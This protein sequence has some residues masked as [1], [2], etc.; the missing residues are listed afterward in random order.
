MKGG[1]LQHNVTLLRS[2]TSAAFQFG[3]SHYKIT[4]DGVNERTYQELCHEFGELMERV[5]DELLRDAHPEDYVRFHVHSSE[6]D[7]DINTPFQRRA[8]CAS[9]WIVAVIDKTMQSHMLIDMND[10][11]FI[12]VQHARTPTGG[13][14]Q[15]KIRVDSMENMLA[16]HSVITNLPDHKH[17]PCFGYALLASQRLKETNRLSLLRWSR[18]MKKVEREV[19]DLFRR[20]NVQEG[21]VEFKDYDSFQKILPEKYRLVVVSTGGK[22]IIYKGQKGDILLCV[23]L[24]NN[25][26][27][28]ALS[29]LTSWSGCEVYCIEC[30][31]GYNTKKRHVCKKNRVCGRCHGQRCSAAPKAAEG[32]FCRDCKGIFGNSKCYRDHLTNKICEAATTC[33]KCGRWFPGVVSKH[34][35]NVEKCMTCQ[36]FHSSSHPC[37]IETLD[38]EVTGEFHYIFYDFEAFQTDTDPETGKHV[39]KV[40]FCVAMEVCLRCTD[41]Q[42]CDCERLRVFRGLD[43][44]DVVADFLKWA[45]SVNRRNATLIAHNS[46]GYDGHF[47]LDYLVKNEEYPEM[48]MQGGKILSMKVKTTNSRF[49]DSHSFLAMGLSKFTATFGLGGIEKGQFPHMF[50]KVENYG[51]DG[52]LPDL[53]FYDPDSL[54]EPARSNLLKWHEENK[55]NRFNFSEEIEAYCIADVRLLKDGCMA[56]RSSFMRDTGSDPFMSITIA[57]ACMRVFRNRFLTKD[58]IGRIPQDGYRCT[59]NHSLVSMQ[60]LTYVESTEHIT[61]QHAWNGGEKYLADCKVYA[62]GYDAVNDR[63][64]AFMGCFW[65]GHIG[66]PEK[67]YKKT[68]WN[69]RVGMTM[70]DLD[71]ETQR[72]C[73]KVQ[74][75]GHRITIMYECEWKMIV[76][77]SDDVKRHVEK[78]GV[79]DPIKPRDALFGGRTETFALYAKAEGD[80]KI[81]YIDFRSLY[82]FVCKWK[83]FPSGH[84]EC[85]MGPKLAQYG[86]DISS[87]TGVI[88]CRILPPQNLLI[89]VLPVHINGKLVFPL[90]RTCAEVI[91]NASCDHNEE[92]R[93]LTGC[94]I[95][96]ELEEAVARGYV[97][98]QL[99]EVWHYSSTITYN[100]EAGEAGMFSNYMNTFMSLKIEA[101]GYPSHCIT[102]EEKQEY[103]KRVETYEGIKLNAGNISFN[104][105]T[106][107]VSK[108]SLNNLWGKLSQRSNMTNHEFI[109]EPQKFFEIMNDDIYTVGSVQ[110]INEDCIYVSY[111]KKGNFEK[112]PPNTNSVLA[113]FVTAHARIHLY[114]CLAQI[115]SRVLYCDTDSMIYEWSPGESKIPL[116]E[117]IGDMADE[118]DGEHIVEFVSNG[119]KTYGFKTSGGKQVIKC[120]GFTLNKY[121]S[122]VLTFDAMKMMATSEDA[123]SVTVKQPTVIRRDL[124]KRQ[125]NTVE[126]VKRYQKTFDKRVVTA[127][128]RSVPFG[129]KH[130][131]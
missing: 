40:N 50:N 31:T 63:V 78:C 123:T 75:Y 113:S 16:K 53:K 100:L 41:N 6:F 96:V 103:V 1:A 119:A 48:I 111:C 127:G 92:Q 20:A 118:L 112:P 35:C 15:A 9:D 82:P 95:S 39:H 10:D 109:T 97:V 84:P 122:D 117:F 45:L 93:A 120:K 19:S 106:R 72:W 58:T 27:Y 43:G 88:K 23:L 121:A 52:I 56:F 83:T 101:S 30:E 44:S 46:G 42:I 80:R 29:S 91:S 108:L 79:I 55:T 4:L 34:Q 87:F 99:Y 131:I 90:C 14:T 69:E 61:L 13:R 68:T 59:R 7:K 5:L 11:F 47:I 70:G 129:Y 22:R 77:S 33:P 125:I 25:R 85:I 65:H 73:K 126:E 114:H 2:K 32:N 62:D 89:P 38:D 98:L 49:I 66:C 37:Y 3:V 130:G 107:A 74:L 71:L 81:F 60:W 102:D 24:D 26:H 104:P 54:K 128:N 115:G 64:Y 17:I 57:G 18:K 36:K 110:I 116:G 94:W 51:Y 76:N 67:N 21:Y 86:T 12:T 28:W 105:G 124:Q 8:N